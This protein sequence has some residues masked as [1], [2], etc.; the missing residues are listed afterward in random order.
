[1]KVND[2]RNQLIKLKHK[3]EYVLIGEVKTLEIINASFEADEDSIYGEINTKYQQDELDWYL[4]KSMNVKDLKNTP[5]IWKNIADELGL[6][7][8]NYG[9]L[10][11]SDWNDKQFDSCL[12]QLI[13][14]K[15]TRRAMMIYT[16]P[17]IQRQWNFNGRNDFICTNNV[18]VFIRNNKLVYIVNMRSND[19]V[20]GYKNDLY[21][22]KFVYNSLMFNLT[23]FYPELES[24]NILWNAGSLHVYERH[25]DLVK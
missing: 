18:Q 25:F 4:S 1:M 8:S 9:A 6:I 2:I 19:V 13:K 12:N 3:Q 14:D 23:Q 20:F 21:W 24:T 16:R 22:H 11:F 15:T 5:T 7:N 10:I 17:S